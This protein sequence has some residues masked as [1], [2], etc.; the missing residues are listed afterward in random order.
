MTISHMRMF[1]LVQ[2]L[3]LHK[4][5]TTTTITFTTINT[6]KHLPIEQTAIECVSMVRNLHKLKNHHDH[7]LKAFSHY[8]GASYGLYINGQKA[9]ITE[10][11]KF[12][13]QQTACHQYIMLGQQLVITTLFVGAKFLSKIIVSERGS[14]C[15]IWKAPRP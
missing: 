2:E 4:P 8:N 5:I 6:F 1:M 11:I 13:S 9:P 12:L 14:C 7:N 15:G 3:I 10:K